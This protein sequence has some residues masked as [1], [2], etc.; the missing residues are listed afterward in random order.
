MNI[1]KVAPKSVTLQQKVTPKS[2]NIGIKVAPKSVIHDFICK[3]ITQ[4][5]QK[6]AFLCEVVSIV[7]D[8]TS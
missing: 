4:Y 6:N 7:T 3:I 2:V 8:T 5:I 1:S